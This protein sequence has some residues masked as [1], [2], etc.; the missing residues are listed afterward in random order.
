MSLGRIAGPLWGGIA[1]D[2][3]LELPYLSSAGIIL[4]GFLISVIGIARE[5]KDVI[6][7]PLQPLL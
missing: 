1:L 6:E 5:G 7:P 4:A 3:H 2:M